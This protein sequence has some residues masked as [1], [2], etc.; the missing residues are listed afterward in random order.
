MRR[1][2][3]ALLDLVRAESAARNLRAYFDDNGPRLYSGRRFESLAGGGDRPDTRNMI[4]AEDLVAV[5]MLSVTVPAETAIGLLEGELG[6]RIGEL[7]A[8]I[9]TDVELGTDHADE[10]VADGQAADQAWHLLD[11]QPGI[12]YVIAG[13][14]MARKR[15]HLTP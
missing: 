7:L 15:P 10:L 13:K 3:D 5:Q 1:M 11:E 14:L 4:T 9:P 2:T 12:D 8:A 6:G